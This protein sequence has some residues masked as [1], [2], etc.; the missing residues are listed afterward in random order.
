VA[1]P[2]PPDPL[3][4]SATHTGPSM[5]PPDAPA[6]WG[7][8]R[9]I[10]ELGHGGF[11]RVY[12]A[13]DDGLAK[14]IALK[15]VRP[16]SP[17]RVS[18]VMRE[19][20]M[21]A[22][23]RHPNVVTVHAVRRAGDEV[24]FVMDLIDGESLSDWVHRVGR[25]GAEEAIAIGETISHALAA[26]HGAGVLHRDIKARNVMRDSSGRIVLMDFGAGRDEA[27]S[28]GD[29]LTGTPPY[30]APE[31]FQGYPASR[32]S[33][34]YSLGV[35]LYFLVTGTF[36]VEGRSAREISEAHSSGARRLL[37]DRR[38]DLPPGFIR[39]VERAMAAD[40]AQRYQSAGELL[41]DFHALVI[42]RPLLP[43]ET[44]RTYGAVPS[45]W[46]SRL[47]RWAALG[48]AA[49]VTLV[50]LG[51]LATRVYDKAFDVGRYSDESLL[52]WLTVGL[53]SV[54]PP[55]AFVLM[56][57][58]A[59]LIVRT[60]WRLLRPAVP[61]VDRLASRL[62]S[63]VSSVV[64]RR[65]TA[66]RPA[67]ANALLVAQIAVVVVLFLKYKPLLLALITPFDRADPS[68]WQVLY[69]SA[70]QLGPVNGYQAFLPI[71]AAVMALA[72]R[73]LVRSSGGLAAL[74]RGVVGAGLAITVLLFASAAVPFRVFYDARNLHRFEIDGDRCYE[75][76]RR[77]TEV[78]VF[79]P[80]VIP[81]PT[82]SRVRTVPADKLR[83]QLAQLSPYAK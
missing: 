65:A 61:P 29:D 7:E 74:D 62:Q 45:A 66:N 10:R 71:S 52:T 56:V 73:R 34:I 80:D 8:F 63:T 25:L 75:V 49:L 31:L 14:E 67:L 1:I 76:G 13:F 36:P 41:E 30:L 78:R 15:I 40:P 60:I 58:A 3:D 53:R 37:V 19:G 68:V 77:E 39:V 35:L 83:E 57:I 9:I 54:V 27:A 18:S 4:H 32:A 46:P 69:Y 43:S 6:Q 38:P 24:G 28:P 47:A 42:R 48:G 64:T 5:L 33:D 72:W 50:M 81:G 12:R 16:S 20:Q 11:G 2:D 23:I 51:F 44:D 17:L 59:W 21:L 70:D 82:Q 79:C 55:V 22:R 26:V